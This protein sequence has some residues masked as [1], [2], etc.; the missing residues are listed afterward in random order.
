KKMMQSPLGMI[1]GQYY[2]KDPLGLTNIGWQKIGNNNT[3]TTFQLYDGFVF[4]KDDKNLTQFITLRNAGTAT[5][6]N[7]QFF[8]RLDKL[9]D[10][11]K[12]QYPQLHVLYF[13]AAAVAA[14]NADTIH[15][16]TVL[17]L[18]ITLVILLL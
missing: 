16:D 2:R 7:G 6:V 17:T 4:S 9:I 5:G 13:G 14:A 11:F 3:Y 8:K 12:Q 10:D 1:G 15:Q 18:S